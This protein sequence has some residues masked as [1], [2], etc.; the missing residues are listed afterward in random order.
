MNPAERNATA[1]AL[2]GNG[3]AGQ[4]ADKQA[5]YPQWQQYSMDAQMNG[6]PAIGFEEWVMQQQAAAPR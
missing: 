3:L 1:R 2:L 4:A 6:E 5:L